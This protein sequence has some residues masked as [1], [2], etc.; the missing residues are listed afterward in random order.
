MGRVE[1][2]ERQRG[3]RLAAEL[4]PVLRDRGE[5]RAET[6][7]L[8]SL[9]R[10]RAAARRAGR[11][12]GWRVRTGVSR[13][14]R[15]AWAVSDD[16][17]IPPDEVEGAG[18]RLEGTATRSREIAPLSLYPNPRSNRSTRSALVACLVHL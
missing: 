10:W 16:W 9:E 17:P 11:L 14:R 12:L 18:R 1:D 3:E 13:D 4:V 5:L 6:E 8:E 2:L 15:F 7:T